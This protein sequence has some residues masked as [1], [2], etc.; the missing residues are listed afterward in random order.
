MALCRSI[1]LCALSVY[2]REKLIFYDTF[3]EPEMERLLK[4]MFSHETPSELIDSQYIHPNQLDNDVFLPVSKYLNIKNIRLSTRV[5]LPENP[6]LSGRNVIG[7]NLNSVEEYNAEAPAF[8]LGNFLT[9]F[10]N[11]MNV[12]EMDRL[13]YPRVTPDIRNKNAILHISFSTRVF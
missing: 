3:R 5:N 8:K 6:R 7:V 12:I 4:A 9:T 11:T 13:K 1:T 10:Q 2:G